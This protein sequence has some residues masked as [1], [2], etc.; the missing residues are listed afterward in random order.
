MLDILKSDTLQ[1]FKDWGVAAT[2]EE[3]QSYY[4]PEAGQME[5]SVVTSA[6]TVLAGEVQSQHSPATAA[7]TPTKKMI[8][9]VAV[10]DFPLSVNL[11]TARVI[12]NESTYKVDFISQSHLPGT[13]ALE[14][15]ADGF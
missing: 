15:F 13:V 2:L 11:N 3:V 5:E 12:F 8:L 6:L 4:D 10:D 9:V 7:I 14:C 1:I